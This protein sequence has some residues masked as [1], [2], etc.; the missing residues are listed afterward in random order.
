MSEFSSSPEGLG[1][2]WQLDHIGHAVKD[3][4]NALVSYQS[5]CGF[6]VVEREELPEQL[7]RVAFL[8]GQSSELIELIQPLPGNQPLARF[9]ERRGEGLHHLCY[10]VGSVTDE[11]K[12]LAGLGVKLIDTAPRLGSRGLHIAFLHPN[13]FHGAL[14]EICSVGK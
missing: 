11:L 9:L 3:I 4:E 1:S 6:V 13:S 5:R 10:R 12:R 8:R 2:G 14:I 7:V